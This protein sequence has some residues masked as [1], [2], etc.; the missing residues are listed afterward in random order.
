MDIGPQRHPCED[1]RIYWLPG[2]LPFEEV[3]QI[4]ER[5]RRGPAAFRRIVTNS[6]LARGVMVELARMFIV[7]AIQ[8]EQFP[9]AAITRIIVVIVI[10]VMHRQLLQIFP[11]KLATATATNPRIDLKRLLTVAQLSS[12]A[13]ALGFGNHPVSVCTL[14]IIRRHIYLLVYNWT[15]F[16]FSLCDVG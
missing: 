16:Y 11:R 12:L 6:G 5:L 1:M 10:L 8:A 9:V 15:Q 13:I 4:G 3:F 7:M 14:R 2:H